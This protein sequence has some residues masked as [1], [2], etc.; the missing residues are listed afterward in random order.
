MPFLTWDE[1]FSVGVQKMDEQHQILF[2]KIND[3]HSAILNGKA[4][5]IIGTVLEA[6]AQYTITHFKDEEALMEFYDFPDLAA[7]REE[8]NTFLRQ[9]EDFQEKHQSRMIT[10]TMEIL[11]FLQNWL[12][13][14]I[15]GTDKRYGKFINETP[16]F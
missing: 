10:P 7:H 4:Q 6:A 15:T 11:L 9:L 13:H 1:T 2:D 5:L 12:N 16:V 3:L 14:H 8:H